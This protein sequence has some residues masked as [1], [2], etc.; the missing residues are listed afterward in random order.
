MFDVVG[1][2]DV[3]GAAYVFLMAMDGS[4][5][6]MG[7]ILALLL[8]DRGLDEWLGGWTCFRL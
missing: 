7:C 4:G 5:R 2:D 3:H 6:C 1:D 8:F